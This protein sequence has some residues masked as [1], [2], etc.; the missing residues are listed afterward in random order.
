MGVWLGRL[1]KL[2]RKK[3]QWVLVSIYMVG[4]FGCFDV[5]GRDNKV[6]I[7]DVAKRFRDGGNKFL[8]LRI[9]YYCRFIS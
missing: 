7:A 8:G 5:I 9:L 2:I 1:V 4:Q 3:R 6:R